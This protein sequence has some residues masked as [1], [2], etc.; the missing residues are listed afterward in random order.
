[1]LDAAIR[2]AAAGDKTDRL[3]GLM[4]TYY[5]LLDRVAAR[6]ERSE[7]GQRPTTEV[8]VRYESKDKPERPRRWPDQPEHGPGQ[9]PEPRVVTKDQPN[10][11]LASVASGDGDLFKKLM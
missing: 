6:G 9:D 5:S 11:P 3:K 4:D 8:L 2:D 7:Q 1:M 10:S